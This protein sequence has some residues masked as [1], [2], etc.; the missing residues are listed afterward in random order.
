MTKYVPHLIKNTIFQRSNVFAVP[1]ILKIF[2]STIA[3]YSLKHNFVTMY[4]RDDNGFAVT[5]CFA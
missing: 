2:P 5:S 4:S 1:L 3:I